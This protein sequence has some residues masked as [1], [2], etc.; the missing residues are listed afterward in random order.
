[1]C[2][3]KGTSLLSMSF[4]SVRRPPTPKGTART[5]TLGGHVAHERIG[6][7][8]ARNH[9]SEHLKQPEGLGQPHDDAVAAKAKVLA[10]IID[11]A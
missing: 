5:A 4:S 8:K 3:I 11:E 2:R 9:Q 10:V 1:M 7:D 6:V